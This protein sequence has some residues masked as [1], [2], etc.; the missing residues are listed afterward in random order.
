[1]AQDEI[2]ALVERLRDL[3]SFAMQGI[4]HILRTGMEAVDALES[5]L[6][7]LTAK[8][9]LAA[10]YATSL[11][12]SEREVD[13]LKADAENWKGLLEAVTREIDSREY[14]HARKG[15]ENAPGHSHE[16][17]GVWDWDNGEKAGKQCAWCLTWNNAR[18]AID[19]ARSRSDKEK[20]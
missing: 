4:A 3:K 16:K 1:M 8:T 15:A 2:K 6:S 11:A 14:A 9:E 17:P 10:L 13:G 19:A 5:L 12:Q 7:Q 20:P 18:A